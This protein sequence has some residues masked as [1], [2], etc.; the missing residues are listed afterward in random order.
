MKTKTSKI[1][2]GKFHLIIGIIFIF[3]FLI[4]VVGSANINLNQEETQSLLTTFGINASGSSP[5]INDL[6][7]RLF[8]IFGTNSNLALRLI[9]TIVGSLIILLPVLF[10]GETSEKIAILSSIFFALDPFAIANS[11]IFTGNSLSFLMAGLLFDA[12]IHKQKHFLQLILFMIVFNA[13]GLGYFVLISLLWFTALFLFD[14]NTFFQLKTNILGNKIPIFDFRKKFG[15][16]LFG[17]VLIA[18]AFGIALSSLLSEVTTFIK[19]WAS[20]YQTG[21]YPIVFI[22]AVVSYIPLSLITVIFFFVKNIGGI[23][24]KTKLIILWILISFFIITFYPAHL[25][26]DLM[27]VSL[28]LGAISAILI[29]R[30]LFDNDKKKNMDLPFLAVLLFLGINLT[31]SVITLVYRYIWALEYSNLIITIFVVSVFFAVLVIYR[32]YSLSTS[33]ALVSLSLVFLSIFGS[34]QVSVAM[35]SAGINHKPEK[36]ILWNGY[37]QDRDI[38]N[39]IMSTTKANL[40]GTKGQ[41]SIFVIGQN[42]PAITWLA[43]GEKINFGQSAALLN[44]P[45]VVF[46][47]SEVFD[48]YGGNYQGQIYIANSYP[49]WTWDPLASVVSGDYWNWLLFRDSQQFTEY[50]S[51]WISRSVMQK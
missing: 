6:I 12:F 9:N 30:Y 46:S 10:V 22:F 3:A 47:D 28:P 35:R 15:L 27:W 20:S 5:F 16:L 40:F 36:E 13:R 44:F 51:I 31:Y 42:N 4:R 49:L 39:K 41:L 18:F 34:Y 33:M 38:V 23:S 26:V 7:T 32:A 14:R 8:L 25:V 24:K 45:D 37:F 21:N 29:S 11:I 17:L 50:N 1:I 48:A 2:I 43:Q 19:G